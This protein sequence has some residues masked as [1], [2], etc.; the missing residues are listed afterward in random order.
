MFKVELTKDE[1]D[2]AVAA[3][4]Y[5]VEEMS[6]QMDAVTK[7]NYRAAFNKVRFISEEKPLIEKML[8]TAVSEWKFLFDKYPTLKS[9]PIVAWGR[10]YKYECAGEPFEQYDTYLPNEMIFIYSIQKSEILEAGF[11]ETL[12]KQIKEEFTDS[13]DVEAIGESIFCSEELADVF[14][15]DDRGGRCLVLNKDE[16]GKFGF[17]TISCDSDE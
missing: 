10:M 14:D 16:S 12:F 6:T 15:W 5:F 7:A 17:S 1:L 8:E 2:C 3:L 13:P 4:D 11:D 9:I